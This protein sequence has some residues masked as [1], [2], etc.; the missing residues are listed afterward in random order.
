MASAEIIE[1]VSNGKRIFTD[2]K[3]ECDSSIKIKDYGHKNNKKDTIDEKAPEINKERIFNK[4]N[5]NKISD[6][7]GF[8]ILDI[9]NIKTHEDFFQIKKSNNNYYIS[10]KDRLIKLNKNT[11]NQEVIYEKELTSGLY[12]TDMASLNNAVYIV[13]KRSI[14]GPASMNMGINK[15]NNE[16]NI[17]FV[18]VEKPS[19]I[20]SDQKTLW[21]GGVNY[22]GWLDTQT[23]VVHKINTGYIWGIVDTED[24]VWFGAREKYNKETGKKELI[25]GVYFSNKENKKIQHLDFSLLASTDVFGLHAENDNLWISYGAIGMGVSRYNIKTKKSELLSYSANGIRLG[26]YNFASNNDYIWM[27]AH[28]KLIRLDKISL[29]AEEYE[30]T[31]A[32]KCNIR[33]MLHDGQKLWLVLGNQGIVTLY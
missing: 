1:C 20:F 29:I 21:V 26:G 19:E 4:K 24:S 2:N 25:G 33:D 7:E 31:L 18:S 16:G 12:V 13:T 32:D 17:E 27:A 15:I 8:E 10:S 30:C 23:K 5:I 14:G 28:S 6:I 22:S 9:K 11:N 3:T